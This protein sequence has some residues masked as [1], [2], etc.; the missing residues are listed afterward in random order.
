MPSQ[1]ITVG[2]KAIEIESGEHDQIRGDQIL[3]DVF[4]QQNKFNIQIGA[5]AITPFT[6]QVRTAQI[7]P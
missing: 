4:G 1:H 6:P 7:S 5:G 2:E 3:K